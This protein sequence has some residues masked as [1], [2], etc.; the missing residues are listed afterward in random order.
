MNHVQS[1]H[2]AV[3]VFKALGEPTRLNIVKLLNKHKELS[4]NVC[5]L[6]APLFR[7]I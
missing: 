2:E 5:I 3:K 6:K 1:H 7:I 4:E